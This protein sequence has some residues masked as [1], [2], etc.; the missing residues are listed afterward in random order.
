[1]R[2]PQPFYR[3]PVRFDAERLRGEVEALPATAWVEHPNRID[4]N[5]SVRLI[6]VDGTENDNLRGPML[7]TRHLLAA[8]YLRQVL[9]SFGVVWS[10][11]RLMRLAPGA[12]V[13][14]HAD[15][16][17]HWF[18]RVRIHIPVITHP[19]V[20]FYCGGESVHMAA[21]EAWLF[22]NWRRHHVDNAS[23]AERVHLVADTTGTAAFWQF[24]G[25]SGTTKTDRTI[26][27]QPGVDARVVTERMIPPPVMHPAEVEL[28]L[29]DFI[30]ELSSADGAPQSAERMQRYIGL[31]NG[32]NF[33]WRQLY[34]LHGQNPSG[35]PAFEALLQGLRE[36]TQQIAEGLLMATNQS[37]A[38]SVLESRLLQHA[39]RRDEE[40][41]AAASRPTSMQQPTAASV[42]RTRLE[43]PVFIVSAPRSGSTLLFETLAVSPQLCTVGGEAHWLVEQF[44]E[45]R[46]GAAGIESHRLGADRVT[47]EIAQQI[48]QSLSRRL[49]DCERQTIDPLP[50]RQ[51]RWLEKTPKNSL[52]IPFFEKLFPDALFLFLWRDPR[53]N[54]SSIMEA[55]R[56]GGWI[57]CPTLEGWDGPWS[58]L[59]PPGWQQL[60]GRPLEEVAAYQWERTNAIILGDL[61]ARSRERWAVVSYGELLHEPSRVLQGICDFAGLAYDQA[62]AG[63][64]AAP[65]PPS[66]HTLTPPEEGKWRVN[67]A[68]VLRV[69]P[70]L[71][72][73]W[74]RLRELPTVMG[75]SDIRNAG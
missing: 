61:Q 46:P 49:V 12:Q 41:G 57:T 48:R 22:D 59:L 16:S 36:G 50:V 19:E 54:V 53:E 13:P 6:T 64:A 21:G 45:L 72:R 51:L 31:L 30:A 67:E 3:L 25:T 62:L 42:T 14:A 11:S 5:T 32:F 17:Y 69:L 52:R 18:H 55:W 68:A 1:M 40:P 63:R 38:Q 44:P 20:R 29:T 34:V 24:V 58:L 33:D 75:R 10:R 4:G 26:S 15:A 66:R 43:R 74:Q 70:S 47:A 9:A 2:L 7:P 28:L 27:Y 8:P 60:R 37:P 39:L 73:T 35:M 71:E 65:L 56:A 23:D